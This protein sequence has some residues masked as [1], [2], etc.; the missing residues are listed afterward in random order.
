MSTRIYRLLN[1]NAAT[2]IVEINPGPTVLKGIVVSNSTAGVVYLKLYDSDATGPTV[3]TTAVKMT[4]KIMTGATSPITYQLPIDGL[5]FTKGLWA[6]LTDLST[7]ADQTYTAAA[8]TYI[9]N[10]FYE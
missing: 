7:D 2:S 10:L 1:A 6:N 8:G 3:G 4:V 9:V 5:T